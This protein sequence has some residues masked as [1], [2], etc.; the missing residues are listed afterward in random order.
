MSEFWPALSASFVLLSQGDGYLRDIIFL[1]LQ[2][3][4]TAVAIATVVGLP[5]GAVTALF[6]FPGR[7]V[8]VVLLNAL[9][10][11]P[12]VVVGL[13]V[14]LLLSRAGPLG[15]LGLLFTPTAMVIAQFVLVLPIVAALSRQVMEGMWLE[16]RE[17][18]QSLGVPP[19]GQLSVLLWD[20]RFALMTAVLAGFGRATA[21][22]GAVMIV[23]GNIDHVTRVMTTTIALEASKGDLAKALGLGVVLLL[24]SLVVNLLAYLL[25]ELSRLRFAD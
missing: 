24:V 13:V 8:L 16:Y 12:P 17:Q 14:Y 20:G 10:G 22:V 15:A 5:I 6:R 7:R 2:V 19:L 18:L 21:E 3:S 1:S 23:G 4:L 25:R 11:L 9:M